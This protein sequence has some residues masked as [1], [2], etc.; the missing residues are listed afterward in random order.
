[1]KRAKSGLR[2]SVGLLASTIVFAVINYLDFSRSEF[3]SDGWYFHGFP[4][5]FYRH[6]GFAHE[7]EYVWLGLLADLVITVGFGI[8]IGWLWKK[9]FER[10]SSQ[11]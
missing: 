7:H 8:A 11:M 10:C 5:T 4:F 9:I 6:G 3:I 1:M 2:L